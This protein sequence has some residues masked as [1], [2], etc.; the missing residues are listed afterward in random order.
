M[1]ALAR[2]TVRMRRNNRDSNRP[3]GLE[4]IDHLLVGERGDGV[5]ANFDE[6]AALSQTRLPGVAEVLHLGDEAVVLH[7]EPELAQ[8]VPPRKKEGR[9][10]SFS[11]FIFFLFKFCCPIRYLPTSVGDPWHFVADPDPR[12]RTYD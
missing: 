7:V 10:F 11:I 9:P 4:Q 3:R 6:P 8:L 5:A 1:A 2:R 12:I